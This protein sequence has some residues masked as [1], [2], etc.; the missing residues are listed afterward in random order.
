M[1]SGLFNTVLPYNKQRILFK[2][3]IPSTSHG[4][5]SADDD[6]DDDDDDEDDEDEDDDDDDDDD[7][8]SFPTDE[9]LILQLVYPTFCRRLLRLNWSIGH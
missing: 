4:Y 1:Y 6:D 8:D 3:L 2:R 5:D 9:M 7:D